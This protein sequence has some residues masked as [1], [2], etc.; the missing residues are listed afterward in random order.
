M[1]I[2]AFLFILNFSLTSFAKEHFDIEFENETATLSANIEKTTDGFYVNDVSI[3]VPNVS[4]GS[5]YLVAEFGQG[6]Y[7]YDFLCEKLSNIVFQTDKY[8]FASA[9]GYATTFGTF[10][11]FLSKVQFFIINEDQTFTI[12][13]TYPNAVYDSGFSCYDERLVY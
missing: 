4:H 7:P 5:L 2:L 3:D 6:D 12:S 10:S 1:K 9:Y 8:K 13:D 11:G